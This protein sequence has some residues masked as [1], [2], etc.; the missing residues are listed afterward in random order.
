MIPKTVFEDG[1][2]IAELTRP[3]H[4]IIKEYNERRRKPQGRKK[5]NVSRPAKYCN[6]FTIGCWSQ[7]QLAAKT[8]GPGMSTT[9]IVRELRKRDPIIFADIQ[10]TTVENWI[11]RSMGVA[12]WKKSVVDQMEHGH[13]NMPGHSNGG[14]KGILARYPDLAT[15]I[16][17][18]LEMLREAG[19]PITVITARG[20]IIASALK[21]HPEIF[22]MQF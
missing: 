6:W 14:R 20:I 13:G 11:D 7:N 1:L 2:T 18:Q 21:S 12:R 3:K 15:T 10:R 4:T 9:G 5:K 17:S 22:N 8:V 19:A 16:C